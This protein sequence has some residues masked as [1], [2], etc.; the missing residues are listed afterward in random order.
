MRDRLVHHYFDINLDVLWSTV[1][2][3]LPELL[4]VVP[5]PPDDPVGYDLSTMLE[6]RPAVSGFQHRSQLEQGIGGGRMVRALSGQDHSVALVPGSGIGPPWTRTRSSGGALTKLVEIVGEAA[7]Q[8]TPAPPTRGRC[9]GGTDP[10]AAS[11]PT[12]RREQ[13]DPMSPVSAPPCRPGCPHRT[14]PRSPSPPPSRSCEYSDPTSV[15]PHD[16]YITCTQRSVLV[17]SGTGDLRSRKGF[18]QPPFE[19]VCHVH[20]PPKCWGPASLTA[21]AHHVLERRPGRDELAVSSG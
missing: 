2:E 11:P 7:N 16:H 13:P 17:D 5:R 21:V 9:G 8:V 10:L 14:S 3:D 18:V 20:V 15:S 1:V 12:C 19:V 4:K 6:R